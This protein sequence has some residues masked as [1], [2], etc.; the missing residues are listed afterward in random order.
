MLLLRIGKSL[1][2]VVGGNNTQF[3]RLAQIRNTLPVITQEDM[4]QSTIEICLGKVGVQFNCFIV[5]G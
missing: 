5:I 1:D 2:N 3:T 4:C